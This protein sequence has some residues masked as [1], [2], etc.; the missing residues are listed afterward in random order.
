MN[1]A[2]KRLTAAE[3]RPR[4]TPTSTTSTRRYHRRPPPRRRR[5]A[6]QR[7][8]CWARSR[9]SWRCSTCRSAR[10]RNT[11]SPCAACRA[12]PR[13]RRPN[14][15]R[16]ARDR[17]DPGRRPPA[18]S[19]ANNRTLE[20]RMRESRTEIETLRETLEAT[21]LESLTDPL[22]GLANRKHFEEMLRK[23]DRRR[24]RAGEPFEPDRRSTSTSSSASTT[25]TA[26]SPAIRCCASWRIVM[27]EQAQGTAHPRPLR[28]RGIRHPAARAPTATA[29][30][31][32][33]RRSAPA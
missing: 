31:R 29:A 1:D 30:V 6:N 15:A 33:P 17:R 20:A 23:V 32:S 8:A 24:R 12:G 28:R 13:R 9:A 10:R 18:R 2:I 14:R 27:R 5:R 21:R 19:R 4:P 3:R 25:S 26:I 22:T 7:A 16:A 11:A